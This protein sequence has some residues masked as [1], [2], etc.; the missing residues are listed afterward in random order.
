MKRTL[1]PLMLLGLI[2]T[3][4]FAKKKDK[5]PPPA[6]TAPTA[7]PP[8]PEAWRATAPAAATERPWAPPV[9]KVLTLS[10]GI[11]VYLVEKSGLPLVSVRLMVGAGREVNPPGKA[12]LAALTATMLDEGTT[13]RTASRLA[14]E[15]AA[16]GAILD[17]R[18]DAEGAIVSLDAL[19]GAPLGPSLDLFADVALHPAFAKADFAR[20][21][22]E[23]LAGI[24]EARSEPRDVAS[25]TTLAQIYGV[26]HPYGT[27][28]VGTTA[29]VT[30]LKVE[31][32]KKL[33]TTWY[34]AGNAALV[35]T[36][37]VTE[38][39]VRALL[40]PRFGRWV[41]G[42]TVRP[43]P[44]AASAPIKTRVVFVEQ[45]GAV[46]SVVRTVTLGVPRSAPEFFPATMAVT[47]MGGMFSAPLNMNLRE[48]HGWSYGAYAWLSNSRDAGLLVASSSVQA[49][50][51]G[52]AVSE[53]LKVLAANTGAPS[54]EHLKMGKDYLLKSLPGNYETNESAANT[55]LEIPLYGLGPDGAAAY[56][57]GVTDVTSA[58]SALSATRLFD[59]ARTLIVVVGPR[60]LDVDDG[61]GGKTTIDVPKSLKDLGFEYVEI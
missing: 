18:G 21:K 31:D 25:R 60:T 59:P 23:T 3:P 27:P 16:L 45:P 9:A 14:E 26:D 12:G 28:M 29:S 13:T 17:A 8:D 56:V 37:A 4:A 42:K 11:P 54:A 32:A 57:K 50:K 53:V 49:D 22:A 24:E 55:L 51:T 38:A 47:L 40:E 61:K 19:T 58:Q 36:G 46:Q 39:D 43:T 35:V 33:Y 6:S 48:E 20:V 34:H 41:R 15:A 52:P 1:I 5:G 44:P 7:P 10:N 30:G 2:A